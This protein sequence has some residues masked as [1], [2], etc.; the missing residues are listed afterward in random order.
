M[1]FKF[2]ITQSPQN[3]QSPFETGHQKCPKTTF[4]INEALPLRQL[5][6][7]PTLQAGSN[8][9]SIFHNDLSAAMGENNYK[10]NE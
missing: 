7:S 5:Q 3:L 9:S 10:S 2:F 1:A 8:I 6:S 4:L